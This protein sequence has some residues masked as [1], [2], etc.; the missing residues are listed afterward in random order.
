MK[1]S[2]DRKGLFEALQILSG[3]IPVRSVKPV[4][5]HVKLLASGDS[6][7]IWGTDLE[8]SLRMRM[9]EVEIEREGVC[10]L[11]CGKVTA[12]LREIADERV[13]LDNEGRECRISASSSLFKLLGWDPGEFP[14]IPHLPRAGGFDVAAETL[15]EMI[16]KT[17][18]AAAKEKTRY[19]L[20]GVLLHIGGEAIE[21][22]A[23][24][25]RRLARYV[26]P[27]E[28]PDGIEQ[29][30]LLPVKG[31]AQL[32]KLIGPE[33]EMIRLFFEENTVGIRTAT[34]ELQVRQVEGVFPDFEEVIPKGFE[35]R[36]TST[37]GP[38]CAALRKASIL[39][40][41]E[42]R[43]VQIHLENG[44]A[45]FTS[46]STDVGESK[47]ELPTNI[48]GKEQDVSFNPEFL[49]EGLRVLPEDSEFHL[50]LTDRT[51]PGR[52]SFGPEYTYVVMPINVE[53]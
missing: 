22:V 13:T 49:L 5:H 10:V 35:S 53:S 44:N 33:D 20:N 30:A 31:L 36:V 48:D 19:A 17:V 28:N 7:E 50:D 26:V 8:I 14:E 41:E 24:D 51:S 29:R 15:R 40:S 9:G 39:T 52:I 45:R 37:A 1:F 3:V 38:F 11:P 16:R 32:D 46:R 25:G 18:F 4:L 34:A 2:A 6:V 12:I 21:M 23:T 42:T 43:A 27:V 47:V